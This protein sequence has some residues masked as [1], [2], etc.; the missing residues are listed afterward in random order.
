VDK[1]PGR[2]RSWGAPS[3][4]T[5][6]WRSKVTKA[7]ADSTIARIIHL[8]ESAREQKAQT[9][10]F[11]DDLEQKYSLGVV[12]FTLLVWWIPIW[13]LGEGFSTAFYRAMTVMVAASPCA[14]IISTPAVILS[15]I[16]NAA[17][18]GILFKG[19]LFMEKAGTIDTLAFDKTG[20][21]TQGKPTVTDFVSLE[22]GRDILDL[23]S[24]FYTLES[25]SEHPLAKAAVAYAREKGAQ[26]L[27]SA[28]FSASAGKGVEA[29]VEGQLY[30]IK[31]LR[32][33]GALNQERLQEL[34]HLIAPLESQGKTTVF[35]CR[36][37]GGKL[38]V[39][40]YCAFQD[41]SRPESR[42]V[43]AELHRLGI[44]KVVMLTGDNQRTA[45][46]IAQELGID[47]VRAEL[48]PENKQEIIQEL[49]DQGAKVAMIG[50]GVND[51]P[52]LALADLGIAMGG[53]GTDVAMETADVVLMGDELEKIPYLVDLS[54]KTRRTLWFN[55]GLAFSLIFMM[56][57]AIFFFDLPLPLAV[58]GHEGGT[59]LVSLNGL[60]L[61]FSREAKPAISVSE[62]SAAGA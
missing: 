58:L 50:D 42:A 31:N 18:K 62:A 44:K 38:E 56:I 53:A 32:Y 26:I 11:L 51:A 45:D 28:D 60:R 16:G 59:V 21:L 55:L 43:V 47:E 36:E 12:I 20:T 23:L 48:L 2:P 33:L 46:H 39:L 57:G 4:P 9:Q 34:A 61:F 24:L 1:G 5:A 14:L 49:K 37:T 22:P 6:A 25:H 35:L 54:R 3:T 52:A 8:V 40:A 41:R 7:A 29:R 15:A 10:S 19:G 17:R 30:F 27:D 13:F